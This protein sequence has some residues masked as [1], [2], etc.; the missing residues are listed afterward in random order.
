MRERNV[1]LADPGDEKE[2][3]KYEEQEEEREKTEG[4]WVRWCKTQR[5]CAEAGCDFQVGGGV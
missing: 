2:E 1:H 3:E 5:E 4:G